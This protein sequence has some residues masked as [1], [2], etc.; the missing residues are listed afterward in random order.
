MVEASEGSQQEAQP[1]ESREGWEQFGTPA[2]R[3][4]RTPR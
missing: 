1:G 3:Q 4:S 2:H